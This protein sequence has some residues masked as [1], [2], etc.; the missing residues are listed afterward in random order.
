MKAIIYIFFSILAIIL[1][2]VLTAIGGAIGAGSS[3]LIGEMINNILIGS[4][5]G[6]LLAGYAFHFV[7]KKYEQLMSKIKKTESKGSVPDPF[8]NDR[9]AEQ[10][11]QESKQ[12][13]LTEGNKHLWGSFSY[14]LF[15]IIGVN[16]IYALA[17][18]SWQVP[19]A[20]VVS[21]LLGMLG[22][23]PVILLKLW[24]PLNF[25]K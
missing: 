12:N 5:F 14:M 4:I 9:P 16:A 11:P 7:C 10:Q 8:I 2:A 25:K 24:Q 18:P 21:G 15:T 6:G 1:V 19:L 22:L 20:I 13:P 17:G 23:I 3:I